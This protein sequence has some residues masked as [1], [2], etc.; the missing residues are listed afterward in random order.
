MNAQASNQPASPTP[1]GHSLKTKLTQILH[2]PATAWWVLLCLLV[3]TGSAWNYTD[4]QITD[5]AN[6]RFQFQTDDIRMAIAK[7]IHD[8]EEILQGGVGLFA[9]SEFV[10]R[11]D[12]KAYV[13]ALNLKK[14]LADLQGFGF[15]QVVTSNDKDAHIRRVRAEGF[16]QYR[17]F[18]EGTRDSYTSIVYLEP[19]EG[20][21]LRAFGYDMFSEPVRREA[22]ERARDTGEAAVS[23]KV[24]LV[25]ETDQD[26]QHGFLMYLPVYRNGQATQT[27]QQRRIALLGFV[28]SPFRMNGL[29]SA[30]SG[31][32]VSGIDFEIHDGQQIS[33]DT[34]LYL[35]GSHAH[36]GK[37][38]HQHAF[39]HTAH[40][41]LGG[42]TWSLYFSAPPGYIPQAERNQPL[43]V[44]AGGVL[45]DILLFSIIAS[46]A[47]RQRQAKAL[48]LT[49]TDEIRAGAE[50]MQAIVGNVIDGIITID[51]HGMIESFNAAAERIF[52]YRAAETVGINISM[53]MPEPYHSQHD[54]YLSRY[55]AGGAARI[56]SIGREVEGLRKDGSIFPMDL[57]V[58]ELR[59]G[60]R[61]LFTGIVRDISERKQAEK[62]L[63]E[64][65]RLLDSVIDNIPTM[66][67]MKRAD[68]LSFSLLNKAGE[69]LL[70][71]T[72]ESLIG[73]TDYDFFSKEQADFFTAKDREVLA[74]GF[75][76]IPEELIDTRLQG[77][78]LL[79]TRKIAINDAQGKPQY[80]LGLSFDITERKQIEMDLI[81]SREEANRAN[82]AKSD[83]LSSM[84][85]ELRT[86]MNA[87]LG[88]GQLMTFDNTLSDKHKDNVREMLK[89]GHH[90]LELINEVLDLA[91]VESGKFDLVLEPVEACA[92]VRECLSLVSPQADKHNIQISL[93]GLE[94]AMV[95]ADRT[96]LKQALLNLLSNAIKYNREGGSVTLDVQPTDTGLLRIR[97][98]DTGPGIPAGRL[99]ELFQP[100]NRLGAENSGIEGT[101]IGLTITRRIIEMM[102]GTVNVESEV[103]TGSTFWIELPLESRPGLVQGHEQAAADS[104]TPNQSVKTMQHTVLYIEDNQANLKLVTQILGLRPHIQLLTADTPE[105][106]IEMALTH[107]PDLILLDINLPGMDGYQVLEVF[108]ADANLKGIPVIAVTANAMP[109]DID[110]GKAAGF[111]EYLTKPLDMAR[112]LAVIDQQFSDSAI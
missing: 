26:V 53:L 75:E 107:H 87:I 89:A 110:R 54:S 104:A 98:T 10:S 90:L 46:I 112:F 71:H 68:N 66:I 64:N 35:S 82:Q 93:S 81:A 73:K 36:P 18:P 72:R 105:L 44:A 3:V 95:R 34:L 74:N 61:R 60:G 8:Q 84:S 56:I 79:H 69:Q 37:P 2:R 23:G 77:Q 40:L 111:S 29:M 13:T 62:V 15:S 63:L 31:A 38:E 19:F 59:L 27:P 102:G 50:R 58:S 24:K 6:E 109:R 100:F 47:R 28:Y 92:I 94:K 17:I 70:G 83:F 45:I 21:N 14:D 55:M 99:G 80:L 65:K 42:R 39:T 43:F 1:P 88:F 4:H 101:G 32:N 78:R 103:G 67:F 106:G 41:V 5:R 30:I 52:G 108:K 25:Q 91:K 85:H 9:A 11:N 96:R 51:E 97:V 22:M 57:A 49:M 86:P 48:A 33:D 12:W 20:R 7:R 76:D 16:P